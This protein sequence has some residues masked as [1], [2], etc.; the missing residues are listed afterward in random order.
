MNIR[1][2]LSIV[3]KEIIQIRRDPPSLVMA[4]VVPV[5]MLLIF[6]YAVTT[7]VE[8]IK[9]AVMDMSK[10]QQS[11]QMISVF[12]NTGYFD[13][14]LYVESTGEM[15]RLLDSGQAK[16]GLI[17][18]PDYAVKLHRGEQAALQLLVDGSDPLVARTALSTAQVITQKE[19]YDIKV[20]TIRQAGAGGDFQPA[21]DLRY[22]VWYNPDM[23]SM[24]FNIPGLVGLILQNIT[25]LL[26]AF[27]LVRERERG[28][29]EQ[30]LITPVRPAE[31][32]IGKLIPYTVIGFVDVLIILG[33]GVFWFN[34]PVNGSIVQLLF[35]SLL[36]LMGAL[37]LGLFVSTIA[38][39]QLQAMQ[40][41][42]AIILP[43]VLLSGFMFPRESMPQVI[44][45]I[46]Y[47]LPLTYFLQILR[48]IILK[49]VGFTFLWKDIMMLTAFVIIIL[50][51]SVIRLN[52]RLD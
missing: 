8:H 36:F 37:G 44:Q 18:P 26:T 42:F 15:T 27:A 43:S 11:R 2:I 21:V 30:L 16:V 12:R 51:L 32:I 48:G 41:G 29:L 10:S 49:G 52:K 9:T 6:G 5:M 31:L 17:I 50:V 46:G 7:D 4:F 25:I 13:P 45:A 22:R 35:F 38:K 34:V 33:F 14:D 28:T 1:R 20:K 40:I 24:K 23:E 3:K 47:A 39:T 19:S